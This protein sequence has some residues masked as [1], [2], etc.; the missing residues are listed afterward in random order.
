MTKIVCV[1]DLHI[2]DRP[3]VSCTESYSDDIFE[4]MRWVL[5]YAAEIEADAVVQVGDWFHHKAPGRNSHELVLKSI[6]LVKYAKVPLWCVI[7]NHDVQHDRIEDVRVRQPLGVLFEAGLQE[8]R[9]WHPNLPLFGVP[10]QADWT[11]PGA[12]A[13]ALAGWRGEDSEGFPPGIFAANGGWATDGTKTWEDNA[14]KALVVTHAPIY[15]PGKAEEQLFELVPTAGPDGLS[16]AMGNVGFLYYGHIHEDHGVFEVDGVTY[17]NMGALSRGSLHEYN[18]ERQ[19]K[20]A[21]WTDGTAG[22]E[23]PVAGFTEVV[24]PHKPASEVFRIAEVME[25]RG[26]RLSLEHFLTEVGAHTLEITSTGSVV[27]HIQGRDD[28]PPRIKKRAIEIL[29]EVG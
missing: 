7:G 2:S 9:G 11:A 21:V 12:A 19:I 25:E 18:L 16:A 27:A 6:D 23:A 29:E 17:A 10:W 14:A 15:P 4:M 3:P 20:V 5:D 1:G 22:V 26:E 8:L 28:V 24:V 13:R